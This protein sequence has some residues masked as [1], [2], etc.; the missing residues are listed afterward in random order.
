M[1]KITDLWRG[2][3]PLGDAFWTWAVMGGLLVN[4][5]TSG[6]FLWLITNDHPIPA[7]LVGYG[8]SLPYN[9]LATVGVWRSAARHDGPQVQAD[10]A[11]GAVLVLMA[12]LSLT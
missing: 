7:L 9:A 6:I 4:V 12:G 10:V 5:A 11:R 1:S 3:L 8:L 2:H